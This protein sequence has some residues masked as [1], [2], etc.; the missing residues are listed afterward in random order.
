MKF[1]SKLDPMTIL[2]LVV[3]FGVVIT[4]STQAA[5]KAS[6]SEPTAQAVQVDSADASPI[7]RHVGKS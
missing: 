2:M 3:I 7:K 4:M 6:G 1:L 5:T